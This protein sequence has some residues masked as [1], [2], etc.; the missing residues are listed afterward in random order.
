MT[1]T[2]WMDLSVFQW[3]N[4]G[5]FYN[6]GLKNELSKGKLTQQQYNAIVKRRDSLIAGY[7]DAQG[8]DASKT[9]GSGATP[10]MP[11]SGQI[12]KSIFDLGKEKIGGTASNVGNA[13]TAAVDSGKYVAIGIGALVLILILGRR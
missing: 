7:R 10:S 13:I 3:L 4:Y 5:Q 8:N 1:Y 6:T 9:I 11:S 12:A 2:A